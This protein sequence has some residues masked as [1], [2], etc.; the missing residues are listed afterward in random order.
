MK[1]K[2]VMKSATSIKA[3]AAKAKKK[4]SAPIKEFRVKDVTRRYKPQ[5]VEKTEKRFKKIETDEVKTKKRTKK[6][7]EKVE[8]ALNK[9]L[10]KPKKSTSTKEAKTPRLLKS[11]GRLEKLVAEPVEMKSK[12]R[13]KL[14]KVSSQLAVLSDITP[15][16]VKQSINE[17]FGASAPKIID[18]LEMNDNDGALI[19]LQKRL[20]QSSIAMLT[21]AETLMR[22]TTGAKGTYQYATLVSQIRELITD[23]QANRDRSFIANSIIDQNIRPGFIDLA[24]MILNDHQGF[25]K[26]MQELGIIKADRFPEFNNALRDLAK[27]LAVKMNNK[28]KD[29]SHNITVQLTS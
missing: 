1:K 7:L 11:P 21:Y 14:A 8:A 17:N 19:L 23:I 15:R 27:Q 16:Q 4:T 28:Y 3:A 24:E 10:P 26:E 13:K 2:S 18:M 22:D 5:H 9:S 6:V 12:D 20:L 25:R 29:L